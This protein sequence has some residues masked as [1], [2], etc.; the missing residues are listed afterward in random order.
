MRLTYVHD[1]AMPGPGANTVHVARMCEAFARNGE[2]VTLVTPGLLPVDPIREGRIRRYYGMSSQVRLRHVPKTAG[3][4][5]FSRFALRHAAASG[6]DLVY[7]RY[8]YSSLAAARSG[9]PTVFEAHVSFDDVTAARREAFLALVGEPCFRR[10]VVISHALRAAFLERFPMLEDAIVV[11]HDGADDPGEGA[12]GPDPVALPAAGDG[13]LS[14]GYVGHLYPGK[15]MEVI[16]AIAPLC[17]WA[18]FHIVGGLAA[19]V[20]RWRRTL[21]SCGNVTFHGHRPHAE[22]VRFIQAFDVVLAPYLRSVCA[23]NGA[24][25]A[26]WMSP[27]KIFEYMAYG[28]AIVSSDLPALREILHDRETALLCDPDHTEAW[29]EALVRLRDDAGLRA[30][31]G[32]RAR[33]AF[34]AGHS[35]SQRARAVLEGLE[36]GA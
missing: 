25:I 1:I 3:A 23:G 17:P 12:D 33:S 13:R 21:S 7:S 36:V 31:L 10:L 32:G 4:K 19:D 2:E 11:A 34:T 5:L 29:V 9:L 14:V 30:R 16:A 20:E 27:L 8:V 6:A 24:D 15:G 26:R 18:D 28:K 22:A 35:W